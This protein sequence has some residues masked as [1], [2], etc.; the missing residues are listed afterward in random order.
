M[1]DAKC[2]RCEQLEAD[3]VALRLECQNAIKKCYE[4]GLMCSVRCDCWRCHMV[5]VLANPS[6]AGAELQAEIEGLK[7]DLA[8]WQ[9]YWGCDSPHDS[10]VQAGNSNPFSRQLGKEQ[11]RANTAENAN[12]RMREEVE[13][14][15]AENAELKKDK[16]RLASA[17][18]TIPAAIMLLGGPPYRLTFTESCLKE[19][20]ESQK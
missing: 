3:A 20:A 5:H 9:D 18:D 13:R 12:N 10:H 15:T 16:E 14:L 19:I 7:R 4:A 6:T 8:E 17:V 11:A 2:E 1:S